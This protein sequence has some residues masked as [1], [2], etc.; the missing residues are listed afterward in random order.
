[1]PGVSGCLRRTALAGDLL[2]KADRVGSRLDGRDLAEEI[3]LGRCR[4]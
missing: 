2:V 1:V 3:V 4:Q